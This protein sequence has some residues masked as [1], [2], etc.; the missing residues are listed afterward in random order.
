MSAVP[1]KKLCWQ[2][3]GSIPQDCVDN[4]PY[5]GVYLLATEDAE[6]SRWNPSYQSSN[7]DEEAPTPLYQ[8]QQEKETTKETS[9]EASTFFF[10]SSELLQSL[11][12]DLGPILMLMAGSIFFLFGIVLLLFSHNGFL[13]LQWN[14]SNWIY[15]LGL[16][17]PLIYVGWKLVKDV[18]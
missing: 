12:N 14:A 15:F 4:C 8:L 6:K 9:E 13:T 5:C 17:V 7:E 2:C 3:D 11:K 18:E 16:S 10:S 1:K